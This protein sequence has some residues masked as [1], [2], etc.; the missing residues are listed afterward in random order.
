MLNWACFC[1]ALCKAFIQPGAWTQGPPVTACLALLSY[2][3]GLTGV[4]WKLYLRGTGW[5]SA[6]LPREAYCNWTVAC[7][8]GAFIILVY[9]SDQGL[10]LVWGFDSNTAGLLIFEFWKTRLSEQSNLI[11]KSV[12]LNNQAE[13]RQKVQTNTLCQHKCKWNDN[14]FCNQALTPKYIWR[15]CQLSLVKIVFV[16]CFCVHVSLTS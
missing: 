6:R 3:R 2:S 13:T 12:V 15:I 7:D 1:F 14:Y 10:P 8:F 11:P 5:H 16:A 9:R 4:G